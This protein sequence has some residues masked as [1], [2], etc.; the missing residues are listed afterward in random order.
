MYA[1]YFHFSLTTKNIDLM[2]A[3]YNVYYKDMEY[4]VEDDNTM[5]MF[6]SY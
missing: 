4:G 5:K 6:D 3:Q 2:C 1:L